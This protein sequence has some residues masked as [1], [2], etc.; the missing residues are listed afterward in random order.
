MKKFLALMLTATTFLSFT[1]GAQDAK[2]KAVLDKVSAKFKGMSSL[3]ANFSL[4]MDDA[5]G[6][7]KGS[8]SG[9][10][11]MKGNKYRVNMTGQQII[12]D[13][14]TVWTYL[15]ANKEVQVASYDPNAQSISP[16]KL[17]SG[18]YNSEYKSVYGGEKT[19]GGK[20]VDVIEMTPVNARAFKKV[21]LY[22]DKS[23][24]MITGGTMFDKN[25]GSYGYSISGV[26]PNAAVSDAEFTWDAKKNP[27]V[28]VVDLR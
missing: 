26:T 10:F 16:A 3:K 20:K 27:G 14:K 28:E 17:F 24:S 7:S 18:S 1:A 13:G 25:G 22:V 11:L 12:S 2:A 23:S 8:K 5:K 21:V 6:K 19:V 9:T 4:N 15:Q